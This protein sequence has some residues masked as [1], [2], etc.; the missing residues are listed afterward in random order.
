MAIHVS[1]GGWPPG[2]HEPPDNARAAEADLQ[3]FELQELS[4]WFADLKSAAA[5]LELKIR[6]RLE[7]RGGERPVDE[8]IAQ[9]NALLA[10]V[11][12]NLKLA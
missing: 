7:L 6:V 2:V 3:G 8:V 11:S 10:Q 12:D 1:P 5:G 9:L 4:E